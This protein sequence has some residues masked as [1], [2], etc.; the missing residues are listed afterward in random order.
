[1][2]TM[3]DFA[4]LLQ[5]GA[6]IGIGFSLFRAPLDVRTDRF[7][8]I[9]NSEEGAFRG[10][11]S[12]RGRYVLRKIHS[13]RIKL[14]LT[15]REL[16]DTHSHMSFILFIIAVINWIFLCV[17]TIWPNENVNTLGCFFFLLVSVFSYIVLGV[18]I[19]CMVKRKMADLPDLVD[20]ILARPDATP[21]GRNIAD[22]AADD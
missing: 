3:S 4:S 10:N 9:L 18:W 19:E 16:H 21:A 2:P 8:R 1:M 5:L 13:A 20:E 17:V 6:G 11:E 7:E 14:Q 15:R 12:E 22:G